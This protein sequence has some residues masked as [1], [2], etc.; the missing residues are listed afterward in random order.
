MIIFENVCELCKKKWKR[1]IPLSITSIPKVQEDIQIKNEEYI[2]QM[3]ETLTSELQDKDDACIDQHLLNWM[4]HNKI[5]NLAWLSEEEQEQFYFISKQFV[6]DARAFDPT[7]TFEDI[8]Q[9]IRNVWIILILTKVFNRDMC[10][11]K[12]IFAYS[13][14]YPYTDNYLDDQTIFKAEKKTF[15]DWLTRRLKGSVLTNETQS[16]CKV[17]ALIEMIEDTYERS[18]FPQVYEALRRIQTGHVKSLL[19]NQE[20]E[21]ELSLDI[22]IEKG[23]ASVYA[24]GFLIDGTMSDSEAIFSVAFG[25]LLQLADD[26]QDLQDDHKT[27]YYTLISSY[28]RKRERMKFC[29]LYLQFIEIVIF[30]LCPS[31]DDKLKQ[32][33]I[34]NCRLLILFSFVKNA[35]YYSK[36]FLYNIAKRLPLHSQYIK[37]LSSKFAQMDMQVISKIFD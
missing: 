5:W 32:F 19:Q 20:I 28:K 14:L 23:G 33:M 30:E 27:Q 21:H 2:N 9:A 1:S 31:K 22:S 26:I 3:V 4:K 15:N 6:V 18:A 29:S 11:H 17:N 34:E 25:F 16:Q 12:A 8:G 10:Y 7:M 24:D 35:T 37:D 36:S 13:M